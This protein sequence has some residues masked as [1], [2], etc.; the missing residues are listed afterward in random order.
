LNQNPIWPISPFHAAVPGLQPD[1]CNIHPLGF[2]PFLIHI[3]FPLATST[4][5]KIRCLLGITAL[6]YLINIFRRAF[7]LDLALNT[8]IDKPPKEFFMLLVKR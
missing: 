4:Y 3:S 1:S 2:S 5:S 6:I 8:S 7:S